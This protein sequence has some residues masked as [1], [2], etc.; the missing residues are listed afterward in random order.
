[1]K[2]VV[3]KIKRLNERILGYCQE[4]HLPYID[5]FSW[6]TA[7]GTT[8]ISDYTDDGVHPSPAGYD[9]MEVRLLEMLNKLNLY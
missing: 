5:Y 2:D 7:N 4:K 1:V 3:G 8:M 6:M 9:V